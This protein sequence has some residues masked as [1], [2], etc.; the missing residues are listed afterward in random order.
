MSASSTRKP[1]RWMSNRSE[2]LNEFG[3]TRKNDS[4]VGHHRHTP[5]AGRH[6]R[7]ARRYPQ[8]FWLCCWVLV[9]NLSVSCSCCEAAFFLSTARDPFERSSLCSFFFHVKNHVLPVR[10]LV[11][12]MCDL[13]SRYLLGRAVADESSGEFLKSAGIIVA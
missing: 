9:R 8:G 1:T 5:F 4:T 10:V 2:I 11:R 7:L 3:V 13:S 12:S 6:M